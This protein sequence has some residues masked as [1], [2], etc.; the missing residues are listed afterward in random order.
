M[1]VI[2]MDNASISLRGQLTRWLLEVKASV[3]VGNIS[4]M[5]R[6]RLWEKVCDEDKIGGAMMIYSSNSEQ[7]FSIELHGQ[8]N[9][10]VIDLEGISLIKVQ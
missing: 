4:A 3:F 7:G 2:V 6:I 9:R 1:V 5:V 8:P 10:T